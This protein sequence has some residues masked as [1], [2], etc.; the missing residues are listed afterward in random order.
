MIDRGR[1]IE[2]REEFPKVLNHESI[3]NL[4]ILIILNKIDSRIKISRE[5]CE[6]FLQ[7][8]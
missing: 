8:S 1:I 3:K 2:S 4:P 6:E 7:I 5:T